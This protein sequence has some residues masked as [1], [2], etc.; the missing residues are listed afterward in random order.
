MKIEV[1]DLG[2]PDIDAAAAFE[3]LQELR[4]STLGALIEK[5]DTEEKAAYV[6]AG[7]F[8]TIRLRGG[9]S[10]VDLGRRLRALRVRASHPFFSGA[11]GWLSY[12]MVRHLEPT[13]R[14]P[15]ERDEGVVMLF[16]GWLICDR[17]KGRVVWAALVVQPTDRV[18]A[19]R[20]APRLAAR[21]KALRPPRPAAPPVLRPMRPIEGR[22][23]RAGFM[24]GVRALKEHIRAGDI[25][26]AVLS[27]RFEI[28]ARAG[29]GAVYRALRRASPT[30]YLFWLRDGRGDLLGATPERLIRVAHG[31]ALN[32]P[33]AG[34]RPRGAKA[35]QD[36]AFERAL[37][38][39]PKERAEHFMLVDLARNDLGRV[40]APGSVRVRELMKVR[41]F[42]NLMHLVSQ[43]EGRL[44]RGLSAWDALKASFPAGTVS[45]APKIR[46][47]ELLA[48]LEK[49]PR[50]FY[51]GA[52]IQADLSG[53]IDSCLAIRT[54][55]L[56]GGRAVLQAGAGIVAD[57]D[58]AREYE[59][60]R[61]KILGLR[62]ALA[63]AEA[64]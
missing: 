2:L 9:P 6:A 36:K 21:L 26:Q 24:R 3:V 19:A 49:K 4:G 22:L 48:G 58:P 41:R 40:C 17:R 44:D 53:N 60:V 37:L 45:G 64:A 28:E 59:E 39:S 62:R 27:D 8:E 55:R 20:F 23:G 43:V 46:A 1:F 61:T 50:G 57:S 42:P 51:A 14:L 25:F 5:D 33:I 31:V 29:A 7:P 11:A 56:R 13:L 12:E 54:M 15:A 47:M 30:P 38:R 16:D 34:T 32:C 52:V 35:A 18:R 10:F 63:L